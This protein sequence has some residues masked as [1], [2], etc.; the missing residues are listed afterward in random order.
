MAGHPVSQLTDRHCYDGYLQ[1]GTPQEAAPGY[2]P[3]VHRNSNCRIAHDLVMTKLGNLTI[4]ADVMV[5]DPYYVS[6]IG[7][8]HKFCAVQSGYSDFARNF[9]ILIR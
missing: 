3:A 4:E 2:L 9:L 5:F 6:A 7:H 8:Q 1:N